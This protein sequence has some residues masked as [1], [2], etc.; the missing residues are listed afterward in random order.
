MK[1]Q[2]VTAYNLKSATILNEGWQDLTESQKVYVGRWEKELWPLL[3]Q[4]NKLSEATLT[5]DQIQSIFKGAETQANA[6]GDNRNALGKA[7]AAAGAVAKLPVDVAKKIDA[8]VN[9]LGK[10]AKNAGPVKNADAKFA[11][12]K[13]D[14]SAK[15]TDSKVIQGIQ[16]ISDWAKANPGKATIAVGILT[17]VAAFAGGPLGGAAAGLVLRATKDLLQGEDLSSAVGKSVKTAAY[18]ALAGA[19]FEYISGDIVDNIA[20]AQTA[21]L[22]AM[23]AAMNSENF[24][25]AKADLFAD[26]GMD[27][28]AL[29]GA[30]K[31]KMSGNLNGFFYDYDT[32]IPP[33]MLSKYKALEAAVSGAKSFS[34]EHYEAAG[35][36]HNFM[37]NMVRSDDAKN[38]TAAWNALKDIP[39][40]SLDISQLEQLVA[41]AES[42]DIIL[43]NMDKAGGAIAAAAQGAL[44]TVDDTAKDVQ[45]SK[46]IDP[47]MKK[48][49]ELDLKGGSDAT[50]VDKN[51][52]KDQKLADFGKVGEEID[53]EDR[54]EAFLAEAGEQGELP[55]DNPNTMGAKAKRGLGKLAKGA[56]GAVKGA[57]GKVKAGAKEMGT[58]VSAKKLNKAWVAAGEPTDTASI[59]NILGDAGLSN[60]QISTIGQTAKV[61]LKP[62]AKADTGTEPTAGDAPA[63]EPEATP[64]AEPEAPQ[65]GATATAD[66]GPAKK[67][68]VRKAKDGKEY[69]WMGALWVDTATNKPIG[70]Q[71]SLQNGLGHPKLDPIIAAAKQDPAVAKAI[72]AQ[73]TQAA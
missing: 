55:L 57:A 33:D 68:D 46:P 44:A 24:A 38:L 29:N 72:K 32:V 34:P 27:V 15:N 64:S 14:I 37:A 6:D 10:L 22:D 36:F 73:L 71:A 5:T 11:Q 39:R 63:D 2:E 66:A 21:E 48:Q 13:K 8:K 28:D 30:A 4:Y 18:G 20:T 31:M 53:M 9:E 3:E 1:L 40:D 61:E 49:L 25:T 35:E 62:S 54:F 41:T 56:L 12:L 26:L 59:M 70:V 7:G 43:A 23:E 47:E 42:G 69:K 17:T 52:D 65:A 58:A 45:K 67:G 19:A 16:K 50:P 60:D 51:F